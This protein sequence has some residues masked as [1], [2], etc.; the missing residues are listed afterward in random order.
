MIVD[1]LKLIAF[2][3]QLLFVN[4]VDV[5]LRLEIIIGYELLSIQHLSELPFSKSHIPKI[6]QEK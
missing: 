6:P 3:I 5:I 1:E 2:C 4:V